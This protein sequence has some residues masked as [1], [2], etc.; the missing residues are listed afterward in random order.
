MAKF[1]S[2]GIL[3]LATVVI[4]AL[5]FRVMASFFVPLFLAALLVVIFRP[6]YQR[7]LDRTHGRTHLASILTTIFILLLVLLPASLI[8]FV[9]IAQ[10]ATFFRQMNA[11][12]FYQSIDQIRSQLSLDLPQAEQFRQ[13]DEAL[14]S[15]V[16]PASPDALTATIE[17]AKDLTVYLSNHF[18]GANANRD[19]LEAFLEE[20]D[21]LGRQADGLF[22]ARLSDDVLQRQAAREVYEAQYW[23]V[24]TAQRHWMQSLVGESIRAQLRL[25]A[26][27]SEADFR[28]MLAGA[29]EYLQPRVLPITQMAGKFLL[30]ICIDFAI[31]VITLYFFFA[32]GPSMMRTLMRLSPLDD[33][34]VRQLLIQFDQ[35]SRAVVLAT[36]LSALAQGILATFGY[37]FFGLSSLVLLFLATTFM[38]FIPFLGPA[39]V[40]LPV[41]IYV[42]AVQ[43]RW[44]AALGLVLFGL[45]VVS[46]ID[47]VVRMFVLQGSS[48]L[49]PLL[50]LLSVLGG[51]QVFGP[52]GILVGPMVVVFLQTLLEILNHEVQGRDRPAALPPD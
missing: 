12:G 26:N 17:E 44:A 41:A 20:I 13:L 52:I 51:L 10:G 2:V 5:F 22:V 31:L 28:S 36:V 29:Q 45:T 23:Q 14:E 21:K 8:T 7:I 49:H 39:V 38:A 4:G 18:R 3:I 35:T 16:D 37:W 25:L 9:A 27:P 33:E 11:G 50:A 47:N 34:Y 42:G 30:Q 19:G 48:H 46:M 43:E 1:I 40:W 32:D 24:R 6:L 15:L